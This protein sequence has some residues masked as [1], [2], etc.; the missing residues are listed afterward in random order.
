MTSLP[1]TV[2]VDLGV[3]IGVEKDSHGDSSSDINPDGPVRSIVNEDFS[4]SDI[5]YQIFA[6]GT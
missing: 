4:C 6:T 1:T 2:F 5:T 3:Q